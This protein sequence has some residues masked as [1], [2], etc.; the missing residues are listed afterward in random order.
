MNIVKITRSQEWWGYK[1]PP[2]LAIGY[3][4][5]LKSGESMLE[6]APRLL[7]VMSAMVIGAAYVSVLN[8]IT[9]REEDLAIGKP[10]R[11]AKLPPWLR[12]LLLGLPVLIGIGY[13]TPL[14]PHT[15]LVTIAVM[16]WLAFT[17]YSAPPFR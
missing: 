16:P 10:N 8:D 1:I 13:I 9:D 12:G 14:F 17:L 3:A 5:T 6:A 4:T 2:L 15:L 7:F 11:M